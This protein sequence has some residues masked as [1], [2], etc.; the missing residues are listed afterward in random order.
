VGAKWC[1]LPWSLVEKTGDGGSP[2]HAAYPH[3]EEDKERKM[4]F[5][6]AYMTSFLTFLGIPRKFPMTIMG[7]IQ[8]TPLGDGPFTLSSA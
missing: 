7:D 2:E 4:C 5:S 8:S 3:M 1:S 6:M